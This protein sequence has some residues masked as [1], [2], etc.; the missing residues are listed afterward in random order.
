MLNLFN[1]TLNLIANSSSVKIWAE[2]KIAIKKNLKIEV[3]YLK[4]KT[5][6]AFSTGNHKSSTGFW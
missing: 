2:D 5:T 6:Q 3:F 4:T 1:R